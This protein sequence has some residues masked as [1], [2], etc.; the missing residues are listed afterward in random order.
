MYDTYQP[1]N[2][3][4]DEK[5][6]TTIRLTDCLDLF[7][8]EERLGPQ[9][10]WS[11]FF[12]FDFYQICVLFRSR[13]QITDSYLLFNFVFIS[14]HRYCNKCKEHQQATKKFDLWK[15]PPILVVHL[16][17][18]SYRQRMWRDKLETFVDFPIDEFDLRPYVRGPYTSLP[19]YELYAVSVRPFSF[20]IKI[21]D[22]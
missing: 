16:K 22:I 17:R 10:L 18:F 14:F 6:D 9:D 15:V 11:V 21:N 2:V 3:D 5:K 1:P 20:A 13:F 8:K 7:I 19:V 12:S 4:K